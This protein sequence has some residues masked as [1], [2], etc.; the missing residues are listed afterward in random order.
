LHENTTVLTN[1]LP[2]S[3]DVLLGS[4][5]NRYLAYPNFLG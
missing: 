5:C 1:L 3:H 4:I 2:H